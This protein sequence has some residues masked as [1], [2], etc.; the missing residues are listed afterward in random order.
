MSIELDLYII[1]GSEASEPRAPLFTHSYDPLSLLIV[2]RG[3]RVSII[4]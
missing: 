1:T 3:D 2:G 4:V